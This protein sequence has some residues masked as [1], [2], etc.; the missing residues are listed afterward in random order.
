VRSPRFAL[1]LAAI[2]LTGSGCGRAPQADP[3]ERAR[4]AQWQLMASAA[5]VPSALA[6]LRQRANS[7][8]VEAQSALGQA[9]CQQPEAALAQ[10]GLSWLRRAAA[11]NDARAQLTLGKLELS[12]ASGVP[13]DYA[14]ARTHLLASANQGEAR[15]SYYLA[16]MAR[17]GYGGVQDHAAAGKHLTSAATAGIP[18]ALFLLAN[19]YRDGDG[20]PR[21]EHRAL[22]LY[23]QAAEHDHPESIQAL[24]IAYQNGELGLAR[25][26]ARFESA[27]AEL[28]HA[29]KHAPP[30]P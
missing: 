22:T 24:A 29:Q 2:S 25:D 13:Q 18:Q 7:G 27:Q 11:A 21:D 26:P 16:V 23:E 8:L 1:L 4:I 14:A 5:R 3:A 19:A 30:Q 9:L 28:A 15:A 6:E 17:N 20:V 10:E 12:G